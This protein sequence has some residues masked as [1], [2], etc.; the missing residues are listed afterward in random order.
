MNNIQYIIK[1]KES[2]MFILGLI[3]KIVA[4]PKTVDYNFFPRQ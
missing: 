3:K 2:N 4:A 1:D